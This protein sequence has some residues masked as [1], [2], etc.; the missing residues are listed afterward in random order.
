MATVDTF[1]PDIIQTTFFS[2]YTIFNT[3]VYTLVL[4]IFILAIIK[5]FKK[6]EIDPLSIFFSIV[7]FIFLGCS[8]RALVDN[9]VYPKTV[10]LIT[11][12]LYI[13]VGLL[14]ILSFLFS[15]FLFNK[16]GI[17]YRYT[18]FYI[19]LLFLLPN[20][21][22]FSNLNFTAIFYI[23][24]TWIF[25][26]L[27]FIIISLLVLYIVNYNRYSNF[28][29]VLEKIINYKINFSIVLAHLF[30]AST[31]FVALEYFN[32]SEQHVLP[33]ALN[34]LFDTYITI[35]P[36]KIIVIVAV[37]YII[38]RYFEDTTVKNLLKLT[39]FVLGLAPGLRNI[40]TLAIATI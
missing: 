20:I 23:F 14:T 3:V 5:M 30:D 18:L 2:G 31:T 10:F 8:I 35:F 26:S 24:I 13:L 25:V 6:L 16:R 15:V 36:M 27:I 34:Q 22:L 11:P 12:G 21:I 17:D 28:Y 33:N 37:L 39:V 7:P 32:Y 9:G 4:L 19:G 1:I 38:D 40:L 29:L